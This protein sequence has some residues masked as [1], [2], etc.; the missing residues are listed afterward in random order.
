MQNKSQSP[1]LVLS[2]VLI[3]LTTWVALVLVSG[4]EQIVDPFLRN[5]DYPA[6]LLRGDWYFPKTLEE[7]R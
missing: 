2:V 6:Y 3:T 4:F 7:G 1:S 5:D